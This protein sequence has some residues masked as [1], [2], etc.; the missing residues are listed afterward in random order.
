MRGFGL[1]DLFLKFVP[2]ASDDV[3]GDAQEGR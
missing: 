3:S 1:A 2:R